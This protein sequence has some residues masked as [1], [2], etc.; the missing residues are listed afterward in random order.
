MSTFQTLG[1]KSLEQLPQ[2]ATDL[3][4]DAVTGGIDLEWVNNNTNVTGT[5]NSIGLFEDPNWTEQSEVAATA[6]TATVTGL[7]LVK[8]YN[9]RV[10]VKDGLK[11]H[12]LVRQQS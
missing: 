11:L 8:D 3:T 6:T 9:V 10:S 2:I 7:T 5:T 1:G 12:V 4:T